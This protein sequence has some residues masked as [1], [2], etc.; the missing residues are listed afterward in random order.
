[1]REAV[2]FER[3]AIA[4]AIRAFAD[5]T[6]D[7]DLLVQT[8]AKTIASMFDCF[9][10]VAIV[11]GDLMRL[12][13]SAPAPGTSAADRMLLATLL[14]T[15]P[16]RLD[17]TQPLTKIVET[18]ECS[19]TR[20][21]EPLLRRRFSSPPDFEAASKLDIRELIAV[22]LRARGRATGV[23]K[24]VRHGAGAK[25]FTE[26]D[27]RIARQLADH[28]A[29]AILNAQLVADLARELSERRRIEARQHSLM[30]LAREFSASTADHHG[31]LDLITQRFAEMLGGACVI[32]FHSEDRELVGSVYHPDPAIRDQA[33]RLF[34]GHPLRSQTGVSGYAART[35]SSSRVAAAEPEQLAATLPEPV[36]S[37]IRTLGIRA[38]MAVPLI[39]GGQVL[40]VATIWR[41]SKHPFT[42]DD[43]LLVE[44]AAS[45][46]VLAFAN[47]RLFAETQRELRERT[48]M[49]HRLSTL[50]QVSHELSAATG[51]SH[52]LLDIAARHFGEIV[53]D[54]CIIR[55]VEN[56]VLAMRGSVWHRDPAI[57][58]LAQ[59]TMFERAQ[60]AGEGFAGRVLLTGKSELYSAPSETIAQLSHPTFAPLIR[61]LDVTTM[62]A[63]PLSSGGRVI[64]VITMTCSGA[65]VYTPEDLEIIDELANHASLAIHNSRLIEETRRQL[66]EL[67]KT[68]EQFRHAQKME[69]IGRLAG[70]IAHDFNNLLTVIVNASSVLLEDI[71]EPESRADLEDIQ[72]AADRAADLTRQLLA[73]SRQQVLEPQLVDLNAI[74]A[75]T[76]KMVS[77]VVG[78]DIELSVQIEPDLGRVRSDPGHINQVLMNLV[79]NARDAMP[80]GGMLTIQTCNVG[81][82]VMLAISDTGTGMD[83]ATK[84]RIFEPFFTTKD[85]SKGTGLGLSTVFG[86]VEQSGG[87]MVVESEPGKGATFRIFLPRTD[88]LIC[89]VK[90]AESRPL[91]GGETILLVEDD[92]QVRKVATAILQRSG[93]RVLS[94]QSG[95]EAIEMYGGRLAE[96]DMLLSDVIMPSM[97]GRELADHL[98]GIRPD[99]RVLYMSGY[100]DDALAH[101]RVL[102]P[103][104][105]LVAK[106]FTKASLLDRVRQVLARK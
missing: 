11:D 55:L 35:G 24:I 80:A 36:K 75:K 91:R 63:A 37:W 85:K 4:D 23:I 59:A 92:A 86:I 104:V 98:V 8:I 17:P 67:R 77:R 57:V 83:E 50:S 9:S 101:H 27:V 15:E 28:A 88:E 26:D 96:V 39:S 61:A 18:S 93:Y 44:A 90:P 32:W 70:G 49:Q 82:E 62:L 6:S 22:P 45:H 47:A 71:S 58:K 13:A 87:R 84:S 95:P 7:S 103:G 74:V 76:H 73:F 66:V 102:D 20:I 69:A 52:Q 68:E 105:M 41:T 99:L 43:Q 25:P 3:D 1:M 56:D 97:S 12:V 60:H 46:A 72:A 14:G 65:R 16:V 51:D 38:V 21:T 10:T 106:P 34:H 2:V 78:E 5:T 81:D 48:R 100:T 33:T 89:D 64:G 19:I 42:G 40:A 54:A 79:V 29:L 31:L 30:E 94:A 53:G